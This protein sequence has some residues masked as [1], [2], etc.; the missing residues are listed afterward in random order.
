MKKLRVFTDYD[1]PLETATQTIAIV[2]RKRVGKTYLASVLAE[3]FI[4]NGI[5]I[6]VLDP[7]GAWWGLRSS[8]DG[9]REGFP[10]IIIGG[11]HADVPLEEHSGKVIADLV[12]DNPGFYIIDFS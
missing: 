12:V 8:A 2:A 3:E 5:P 7:T 4:K 10:V 9:K 11:A 1:L 6:V